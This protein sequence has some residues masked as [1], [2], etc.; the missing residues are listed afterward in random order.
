MITKWWPR[1]SCPYSKYRDE[2]DAEAH[3]Y[4]FLQTWEANHVSQRLTEAEV[5]RSKVAEF[6]MT[7]E[8][9]AA[10]WHAQH[11]PGS[12]AT[13]TA[14]GALVHSRFTGSQHK[15]L[16]NATTSILLQPERRTHC[17][18]YKQLGN[19]NNCEREGNH[20]NNY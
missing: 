19:H 8:G 20:R 3:M 6:S 1:S 17:S 12:F 11:L 7:L 14:V 15:T 2:P 13:T 18:R 4:A 9:P 16:A 5:E 10:R